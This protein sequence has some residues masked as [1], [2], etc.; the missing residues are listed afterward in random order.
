MAQVK[1]WVGEVSVFGEDCD[2]HGW[3]RNGVRFR[4]KKEA[5]DY[6][7]DLANRWTLVKDFRVAESS[8]PPTYELVDYVLN[9]LKDPA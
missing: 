5:E 3:H 9:P 6:V 2:S 4:T 8:E 7:A 1:S